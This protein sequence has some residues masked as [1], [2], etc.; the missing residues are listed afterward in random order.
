MLT[1]VL[2]LCLA[3][4]AAETLLGV[5]ARVLNVRRPVP[6]LPPDL[7][8]DLAGSLAEVLK[9]ERLA[10]ARDYSLARARL[11]NAQDLAGLLLTCAFLVAGGLA[12]AEGLGREC[13][14][15]LGLGPTAAGLAFF[16]LLGL[17][18]FLAGLPFDIAGTFGLE[19]RFGF[20]TTSVPT[21]LTDRLKTLA[22]TAL[23]GGPLLAAA[24]W[25]FGTY[26][27]GAWLACWAVCALALA[28]LQHV[29]PA[30]L[31]PLFNTFTPL[32]PGPLRSALENTAKASGFELT[33]ISVMDGSRRSTKANAFFAGFG[34]RRRIALFDTLLQ[35]HPDR[36]VVAVLAHE[37]G[38]ARLGHI[39][40]RLFAGV[41][42]LG[43]LFGLLALFLEHP[44]I[45]AGLGLRGGGAHEAFAAFALFFG[46]VSLAL[47]VAMGALSRRHEFQADAFAARLTGD[48]DGLILALAR[49]SADN[50]AEITA[51]PLTVLLSASH[52]PVLERIRALRQLPQSAKPLH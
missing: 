37:M 49:L 15:L 30:W 39:P 44:E 26:G 35:R 41:L 16:A 50:L 20:G 51:H 9:L 33:D 27:P 5:A 40:V 32:E 38:H 43:L 10:A 46:P 36:E 23:I 45:P 42:Q 14:A 52:P 6:V 47:G 48:A 28:G 11:A 31:M 7:A 17:L 18:G 24:L 29:A 2:A 13:A 19:R 1:P 25:L 12:W 8:G 22:L 34:R 4:L 21:F 3:L